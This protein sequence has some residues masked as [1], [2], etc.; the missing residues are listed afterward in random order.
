VR[1]GDPVLISAE[2]Q[3]LPGGVTK[4]EVLTAP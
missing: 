3:T 1:V 2:L 4:L